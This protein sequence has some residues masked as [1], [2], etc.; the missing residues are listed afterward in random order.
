VFC[1]QFTCTTRAPYLHVWLSAT[2][3]RCVTYHAVK[4]LMTTNLS[5]AFS[6]FDVVLV[7]YN[8]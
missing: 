1:I 3:E 6:Y 4:L 7:V 8:V 2:L 5:V